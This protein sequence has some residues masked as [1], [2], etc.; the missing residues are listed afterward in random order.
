MF[1]A[2]SVVWN[3]NCRPQHST[4]LLLEH[5]TSMSTEI[6]LLY[7]RGVTNIEAPRRIRITER[8]T[9]LDASASIHSSP[10]TADPSNAL[11]HNP[12]HRSSTPRTSAMKKTTSH[13]TEQIR[14]GFPAKADPV[15]LSR[16]LS[17]TQGADIGHHHT[18]CRLGNFH[19]ALNVL[20]TAHFQ[21]LSIT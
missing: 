13:P 12:T 4:R 5:R 10:T 21:P 18:S 8:S 1:T 9:G 19:N 11:T 14:Y 7:H 20:H 2:L 15:M 16:T 3:C 6:R 17:T